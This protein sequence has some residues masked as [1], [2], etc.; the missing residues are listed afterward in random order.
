MCPAVHTVFSL[1]IISPWHDTAQ[2]AFALMRLVVLEQVT[3][4][5]NSCDCGVFLLKYVS[6]FVKWAGRFKV[7][8]AKPTYLA[9]PQVHRSVDCVW[10]HTVLLVSPVAVSFPF[11]TLTRLSHRTWWTIVSADSRPGN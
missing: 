2:L 8:V 1:A 3:K 6:L 10:F 9:L 4:Q 5:D 11:V 7:S